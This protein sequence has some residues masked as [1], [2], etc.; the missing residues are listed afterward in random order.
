MSKWNNIFDKV[1]V[2]AQ[3][4]GAHAQQLINVSPIARLS[5]EDSSRCPAAMARSRRR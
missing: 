3:A 2:Q 5:E 1:K 4:A